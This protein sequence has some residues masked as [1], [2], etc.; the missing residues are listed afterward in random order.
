MG[1]I[2]EELV[3]APEEARRQTKISC[4]DERKYLKY[5]RKEIS[6]IKT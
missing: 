4:M 6:K 2:K 5:A 1:D 3:S